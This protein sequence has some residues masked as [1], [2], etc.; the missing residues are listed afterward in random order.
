MFSFGFGG[1]VFVFVFLRG[2]ILRWLLETRL[3]LAR[4]AAKRQRLEGSRGVVGRSGL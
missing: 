1:G 3:R 2:G 4:A